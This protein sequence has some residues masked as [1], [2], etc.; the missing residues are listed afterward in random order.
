M[1]SFYNWAPRTHFISI[2]RAKYLFGADQKIRLV[3]KTLKFFWIFKLQFRKWAITV[4]WLLFPNST[5][6]VDLLYRTERKKERNCHHSGPKNHWLHLMPRSRGCLSG[7]G[8]GKTAKEQGVWGT[9][10]PG[11]TDEF[12]WIFLIR[13]RNFIFFSFVDDFSKT[14]FLIKYRKLYL[15][16]KTLSIWANLKHIHTNTYTHAHEAGFLIYDI[17][18]LWFW[19]NFGNLSMVFSS[20]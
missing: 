6:Y 14:T 9:A 16:F 7:G 18:F 2:C 4:H 20:V 1:I 5:V 3:D 10:Q 12:L 11:L 17:L 8:E 19:Y 13:V 15:E